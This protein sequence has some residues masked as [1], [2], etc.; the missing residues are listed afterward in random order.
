MP[1]KLSLK[2][3]ERL[4]VNGAVFENGDKRATLVLQNKASILREKDIM[5]HQDADTPAKRIYFPIMMMYLENG[6]C[7]EFYD[8]FAARMVEFMDA[9]TNRETLAACVA[10][11]KD[12]TCGQYYRALMK[13][14]KLIED[15]GEGPAYVPPRLSEN[16][17]QR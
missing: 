2:P 15:E 12:V 7:D 10:V 11:S 16:A 6:G 1:L 8:E 17:A 13:C 14:R 4:V 5:Q 3:R 9:V